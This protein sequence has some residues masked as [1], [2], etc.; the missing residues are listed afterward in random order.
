MLQ[1]GMCSAISSVKST[2]VG[3]PG[4]TATKAAVPG[5]RVQAG[6]LIARQS[7]VSKPVW[8]AQLQAASTDRTFDAAS[9][10]RAKI[11]DGRQR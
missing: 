1:P 10:K 7:E 2:W 8:S 3:A 9:G 4:D 5:D 6:D 11:D